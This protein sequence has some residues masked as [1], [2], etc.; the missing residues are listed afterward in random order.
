M[1]KDTIVIEEKNDFYAKFNQ[2]LLKDNTFFILL[3]GAAAAI[4]AGTY[5]YIQFGTGAF[6]E[7]SI[8]QMLQEGLDG[9]DYSGAA[10]FAAG[11]LIARILEAP[12]VGILDIGGSLMTGVG[13]GIPA[14]FLSM[15]FTL[16][17]NN[18][19]F[20]LITGA[21]IGLAMAA[22]IMGVRK[23]VPDGISVGGTEIMMSAGNAAGRYLGP[24]II[25]AAAQYNVYTGIGSIIGAFIFY[26]FDKEITGGAVLGAMIL[27]AIVL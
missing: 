7:I 21:I 18:F 13:I 4:F 5:L 6:N 26:K 14:L 12:L 3:M 10:G 27:G 24:M 23:T 22:I 15:N 1:S 11:F 17:F 20:A 2:F 25:I 9:G 19:F 16:P 8:V